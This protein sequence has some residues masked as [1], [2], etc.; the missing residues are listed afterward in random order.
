[1]EGLY[2]P[3]QSFLSMTHLEKSLKYLHVYIKV[4][5]VSAKRFISLDLHLD[6]VLFLHEPLSCD[7]L[8]FTALVCIFWT[9]LIN[10]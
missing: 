4:S 10:D 2:H 6:F 8:D 7:F 1:M 9:L 5:K 3:I